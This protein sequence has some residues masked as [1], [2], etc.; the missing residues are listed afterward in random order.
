MS[1]WLESKIGLLGMGGGLIWWAYLATQDVTQLS[2]AVGG[3]LYTRGPMH[4][5]AISLLIWLHGKYRHSVHVN[6][7]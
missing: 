6:R 5:T 3:L 2:T 7:A 1:T 4:I